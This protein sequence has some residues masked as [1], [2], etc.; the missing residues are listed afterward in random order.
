VDWNNDTYHDLLVGDAGGNVTVFL[1][2]N[3][4]INPVLDSGTTVL[5]GL[6]DIDVG[7]RATPIINDWNDDGRKDL[8][9][10]NYD[11]NIRI[12][13]NEG[14]DS[15]RIFDWNDDGYKD[16]IVGE[17]EG[18]A[19]YLENMG[20]NAAPLF[21][22][23]ERMLLFDGDPLKANS[24]INPLSFPRS[25][26][27]ATDWDEDGMPDMIVGRADGK[28]ELYTTVVPEPVSSTLFIVGGAT[29]GFRRFRKKFKK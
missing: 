1:N 29:L 26:I 7:I 21:D 22:S 17:V 16:L 19:Y 13:L 9:I 24:D 4:N 10:G 27:F 20:T 18:Y 15:P 14:T 12:Y 25:R 11:G 23:A 6:V 3:N 5:S 2:A 28:L 8:L